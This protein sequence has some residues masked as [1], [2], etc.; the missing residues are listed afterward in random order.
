MPKPL[1]HLPS[2]NATRLS[3]LEE[4]LF[5]TWAR[6]HDVH[7]QVDGPDSHF[8][9]RKVFKD[10]NGQMQHPMELQHMAGKVNDLMR[11]S[12]ENSTALDDHV[13]E[14]QKR[15]EEQK[16]GLHKELMKRSVDIMKRLK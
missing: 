16:S 10:S 5:Q 15:N 1:S 8:D 6:A 9:F 4:A 3:P 12:K 13:Q 7:D 11:T 2:P 14:H